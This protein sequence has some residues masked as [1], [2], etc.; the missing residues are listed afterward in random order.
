MSIENILESAFRAGDERQFKP[1]SGRGIPTLVL[2]IVNNAACVCSTDTCGIIYDCS[3]SRECLFTMRSKREVNA[4]LEYP[5]APRTIAAVDNDAEN[6]QMP[7][8]AAISHIIF[9]FL[10]V[11]CSTSSSHQQ[12]YNHKRWSVSRVAIH[13]D[14]SKCILQV[15]FL[16]R[17]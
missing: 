15:Q 2:P 14:L 17:Q 10:Y 3:A 1:G 4:D 9:Y 8:P 7:V 12:N 5:S 13:D 16:R 11:P 6:E